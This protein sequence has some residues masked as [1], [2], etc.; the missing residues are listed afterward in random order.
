MT[1]SS[2]R[3]RPRGSRSC[4]RSPQGLDARPAVERYFFKD[5]APAVDAVVSLTGF[6]LV[7]GPAYNDAK[8]AED[9]LA[10]L[11]VPYIAAHALEFQTLPEWEASDRGLQPVEATMM[12]AIP[13]L[14]G[15]HRT[16]DLRWPADDQPWRPGRRHGDPTAT[17][18][19]SWLPASRS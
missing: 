1:A 19:S 4:R 10:R 18:P 15:C 2:R 5:G 6:S 13:E 8:A 16:D 11:D 14:D 3:S 7:G 9:M 12:V 17:G